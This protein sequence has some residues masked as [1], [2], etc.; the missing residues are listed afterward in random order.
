MK[1]LCLMILFALFISMSG[2]QTISNPV[3]CTCTCTCAHA[4][5]PSVTPSTNSTNSKPSE[6][7][8][9]SNKLYFDYPPV[10]LSSEHEINAKL[11]AMKAFDPGIQAFWVTIICNAELDKDALL[12]LEYFDFHPLYSTEFSV[13]MKVPYDILNYDVLIS[14]SAYPEISTITVRNP[15]ITSDD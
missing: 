4:S 12:H 7:A 10:A 11:E 5:Q 3:V 13:E 14:L 1:L 8:V 2:C 15:L 9:S 6:S